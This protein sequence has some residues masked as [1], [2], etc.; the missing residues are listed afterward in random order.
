MTL[1]FVQHQHDAETCPA[2]DPKMGNMLLQHISPSNARRFGVKILADAVLD[3]RH[4]FNLIVEAENAEA[5]KIFMQPFYQA[6]TV[7]IIPA[8]HCETVVE[9]AGC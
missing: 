2:R 3:G 5:I 1:Y 9:R 6:G 8:S 4:T 7:E